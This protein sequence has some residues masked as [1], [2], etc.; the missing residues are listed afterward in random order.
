MIRRALR[1][2]A[3][4]NAELADRDR[5]RTAQEAGATPISSCADRQ[6]VDLCGDVAAVTIKG[7]EATPAL[8]CELRDGTGSVTLIWLGR[9]KIPGIDPGREIRVAGRI[10]R[11]Q[12][13]TRVLFNPKYEL[14]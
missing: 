6:V 3:S 5:R 1:R 12:D 14:R 13:G 4:S 2:L 7:S 9:R 8:E 10:C 11:G